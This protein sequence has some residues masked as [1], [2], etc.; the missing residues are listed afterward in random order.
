MH[1]TQQQQFIIDL[2]VLSQCFAQFLRNPSYAALDGYFLKRI[3][4]ESYSHDI[5]NMV[6]DQEASEEVSCGIFFQ[7]LFFLKIFYY[8]L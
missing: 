8:N 5:Y 1:A 6:L 2:P 3:S 4:I 7:Y